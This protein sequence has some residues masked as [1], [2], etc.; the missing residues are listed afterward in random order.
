MANKN[1]QVLFMSAIPAGKRSE[2]EVVTLDREADDAIT[3]KF[4]SGRQKA[5]RQIRLSPALAE[6][7]LTMLTRE[8]DTPLW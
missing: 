8:L 7:L 4:L 1:Q 2:A 6:N 5:G 3:L